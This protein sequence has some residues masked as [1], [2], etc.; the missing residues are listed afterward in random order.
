MQ[1]IDG[2]KIRDNILNTL[3][4]RIS[5]LPF[6]PVFCDVLVGDNP[7]ST[8]YV[9][10]KEKIA[11]SLGIKTYPAVFVETITTDELISEIKKIAG[12]PNMSG[13]IVQL[14]LPSHID[15]KRVLDAVPQ[16]IDVDSISSTATE[17]FYSNDPVFIFPTASAVMTILDSLNLNLSDKKVAMMGNGMLVG[18]PVAHLLK[19]RGIQVSSI[20]NSTSNLENIL[21][22]ADVVIT[23]TGQAGLIKGSMLKQNVV[24]IDAGT[25]ESNGGIG[26]DVDRDSVENIASILSPVPGGVG[27]VTVA[28]LMQ[29]VVI[30]AQRKSNV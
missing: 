27:P 25:S 20:D 5:S 3:R 10:M 13:L 18:R 11:E 2:R 28:M 7:A 1:I 26:G 23:A 8:Q 22:E 15:T 9:K 29:N 30:S 21:K 14:P 12:I 6:I 17:K 19:N 4:N 24:L 16:E